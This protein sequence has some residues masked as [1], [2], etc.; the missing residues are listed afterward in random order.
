M[1][2]TVSELRILFEKLMKKLEENGISSLDINEVDYYWIV[3]APE[4]TNFQSA[5]VELAVGSL[6]DDWESLQKV[7]SGE[8]IP[9]YLD[10]DRMA[11]ILRA[12]SETI[13]PTKIDRPLT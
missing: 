4:W 7:F 3:L 6:V 11:A 12:I 1:N 8:H 13:I 5:D 10:F 2:I 9:T